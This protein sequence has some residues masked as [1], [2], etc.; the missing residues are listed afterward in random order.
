MNLF[1]RVWSSRLSEKGKTRV[2]AEI[3]LR[4]RDRTNNKP[5][6]HIEL[7][8]GFEPGPHWSLLFSLLEKKLS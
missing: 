8:L 6:P 2:P 7:T 5:S 3:P 4:A 1:Q